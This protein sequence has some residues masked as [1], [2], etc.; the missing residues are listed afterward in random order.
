MESS[1]DISKTYQ[2]I[3]QLVMAFQWVEQIYRQIGWRILD[4]EQKEWPPKELRKESN[5]DLINK[6]T[7]LFVRLTKQYVFP[8]GTEKAAE[9]EVLRESF[10][11][12]RK[13]RNSVLHSTFFELKAGGEVLGYLRSNP[14]VGVDTETGEL[15]YDQEEFTAQSVHNKL[16]EFAIQMLTLNLIH[17]QLIHWMP[18]ERHELIKHL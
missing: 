4:P 8:N 13:Y 7:D 12:L 1:E 6:V 3:G 14:K 16:S 10:H 5:S 9:M 15:I 17:T 11:Q 18:F 2:A